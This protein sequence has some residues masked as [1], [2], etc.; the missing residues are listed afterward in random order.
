[1]YKRH[2][3]ILIILVT[4]TLTSFFLNIFEFINTS[5]IAFWLIVRVKKILEYLF[6][7]PKMIKKNY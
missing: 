5:F 3:Y 6:E 2:V 7:N 4:L 1:M